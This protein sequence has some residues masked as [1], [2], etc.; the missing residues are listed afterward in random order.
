MN[1]RNFL[2]SSVITTG[3]LA[4]F[5]VS[6]LA[7]ANT[8]ALSGLNNLTNLSSVFSLN[9]L[10]SE[11]SNARKNLL[12]V[13]K[14]E[15]Y[16][17]DVNKVVELNNNC[18]A[19]SVQKKSVLGFNNTNEVALLVNEGNTSNHYILEEKMANEF[20]RLIENYTI[21]MKSI[22]CNSDAGLFAF[23]V[24][25][26]EFKKGKESVFSYTNKLDNTIVLKSNKKVT[27]TIIC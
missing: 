2:L 9:N 27:K 3:A 7:S 22:G 8:K 5:P 4:L 1:R 21:N 25:I 18:F 12:T 13:L 20:N 11:F 6:T 23:P 19:I 26:N 10:P 24:K 14:E 16:M 17:F 15:G